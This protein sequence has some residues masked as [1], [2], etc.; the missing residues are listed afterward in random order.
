MSFATYHLD[1]LKYNHYDLLPPLFFFF[2]LRR[3]VY[4]FV[5]SQ[6]HWEW[7]Q[8]PL[9]NPVPTILQHIVH[10]VR[11]MGQSDPI[12]ADQFY[13]LSLP[14]VNRASLIN[15]VPLV[16]SAPLQDKKK[17]S[18]KRNVAHWQTYMF[19]SG[20]RRSSLNKYKYVCG[21]SHQVA[22]KW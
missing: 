19:P 6:S 11:L 15:P 21:I 3:Y 16:H 7:P 13:I 2:F 14:L 20:F 18:W 9:V 22:N 5:H 1:T 10:A 17:K 8:A 4:T 12:P